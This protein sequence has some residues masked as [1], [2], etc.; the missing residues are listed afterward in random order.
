MDRLSAALEK[1]LS[2]EFKDKGLLA[3]ALTHPSTGPEN[4]QRLEFLGDRVLGLAVADWL[5]RLFPDADEG[6]LAIRFNALVR[7]EAC[8]EVAARIDLG[9]FIIMGAGEEK[10][11]GRQKSAILA[12]GC[13]ALIAALYLDGG[14]AAATRFI[15]REWA[16][17]VDKH[18]E[19]P[20]DAKTALQ[21]WAH[22]QGLPA[23]SYRQTA[24]SGPDHAPE[25]TV[26]V[27]VGDSKPLTGKGNSKRQAEQAAAR[28]LLE[29]AG[30]WH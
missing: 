7:K 9:R 4:Y 27:V 18:E 13:E 19:I 10:A 20:Q 6:E 30:V 28:A 23:P 22:A 8:A 14:M 16:Q 5:L 11:G 3:R 24:R 2:Y 15:T 17:L 1:K 25:F 26:E 21:E 29:T 12:D